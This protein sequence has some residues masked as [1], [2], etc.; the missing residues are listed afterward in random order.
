MLPYQKHNADKVKKIPMLIMCII[1]FFAFIYG[2][3]AA[4]YRL[5][6]YPQM[7]A[8]KQ[9]FLP[10]QVAVVAYSDYYQQK[11]FLF[12]T[13]KNNQYDVVFVGDSLTDDADWT[14]LLPQSV[15]A[16]RGVQ[17]DTVQGVLNRLD[18]VYSTGAE[19]A[20]VLIGTNDILQGKSVDYIIRH[21]QKIID[22]LVDKKIS[23]YIQSCLYFGASQL[24]FNPVV[25]ELNQRLKAIA[26]DAEQVH[27]IDIN[28]SLAISS[29]RI[30]S[31]TYDDIHL[32][33]EAYLKWA[34]LL[35]AHL[36]H[37]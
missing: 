29:Q 9:F 30:Q 14:V 1:V 25:T 16:N 2:V 4:H 11:K 24:P 5:F 36:H 8:I 26:G 17:G 21:Y 3:L 12:D 31:Y 15:V 19:K 34:E 6:P 7:L 35:S 33:G 23:V 27:Y 10:S 13:D 32:T 37:D 28:A 20:F 22:Q 18:S